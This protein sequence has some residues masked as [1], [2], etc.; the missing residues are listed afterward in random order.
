MYIG[1]KIKE[2]RK[3]QNMKLIDLAA[4]TGIQIATLSRIEN[5]KMTGTLESHMQIA[6][7]LGTDV[8]LLYSDIEVDNDTQD[9]QLA[10]DVFVHS[11]NSSYEILTTRLMSR[12][13]MPILLKIDAG[14]STNAE[15]GK[16]GTERF[17][18]ILKGNLEMRIG[19]QTYQVKQN[20]T[21]HFDGSIKHT[22]INTSS[23]P[24]QA[25]VVTTPILL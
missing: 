5:C 25:L 1:K 15:Q 20:N 6:K 2:L 12:K 18:Y 22:F 4:K 3:Q 23:E 16:S 14:G 10:A 21:L 9:D 17:V 8:T 24:A 13:M 11:E 19:D 7:A